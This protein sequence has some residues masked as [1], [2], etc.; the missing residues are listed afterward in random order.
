MVPTAVSQLGK[1]LT[2]GIVDR[3]GFGVAE[4]E[5]G[6]SLHPGRMDP[7]CHTPVFSEPTT[8]VVMKVYPPGHN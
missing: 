6:R 5:C 3:L 2:R 7:V 1:W 4:P 8:Y